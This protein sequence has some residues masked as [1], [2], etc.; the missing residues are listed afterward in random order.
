MNQMEYTIDAKNKILGRL[1]GEAA[2]MLRGKNEP[3]FD[4]RV[5]SGNRVTVF[6][7][8]H[9]RVT[10]KKMRQKIY[11]RHSGYHGGLKREK[12]ESVV[13]RDSRIAIRHAVMGM[14]PKNRLRS[15]L[16]KNLILVKGELN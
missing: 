13:A 15:R 4:P 7:T 12:L 2:L 14:L 11:M 9:I 8:D 16:I 3:R 6:H 10:G 1:A 5:L